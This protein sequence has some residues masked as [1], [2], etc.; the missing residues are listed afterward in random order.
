MSLYRLN[1]ICKLYWVC[2]GDDFVVF[3]ESS[4]QTHYL[5]VAQALIL[6]MLSENFVRIE[7]M[8]DAFGENAELTVADDFELLVNSILDNFKTLGLLDMSVR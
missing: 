8:V 2:W 7:D 3:D 5:G 1:P 4:G 6:D